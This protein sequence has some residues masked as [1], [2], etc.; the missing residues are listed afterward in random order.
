MQLN[1][2]VPYYRPPRTSSISWARRRFSDWI[3][4]CESDHCDIGGE[5]AESDAAL[6]YALRVDNGND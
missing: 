6:P 1:S 5:L 3:K 2:V 4:F